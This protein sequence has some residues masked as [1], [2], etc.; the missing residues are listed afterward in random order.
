M[1]KQGDILNTTAALPNLPEGQVFSKA[2]FREAV[3]K[4]NPECSEASINWMLVT[5]RK[6]GILASAGAGKYYVVPKQTKAKMSYQYPH[7]QEYRDLEN[8]VLSAYPLVSFQMWE[9][10]QMNDFVNHQ[11]AKNVIFV[12]VESMMTDT[13]YETLHEQYPYAMI[14]PDIN[15]FFKQRAPGTDIVVQKLITEAPRPVYDRSSPL[16]KIIV[17]LFS[18]KLSGNLIERS[19]Y[20]RIVE[21]V[22]RKYSIDETKLL[23]YARRRHLYNTLLSFIDS[24]TEVKLMT[25]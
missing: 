9:L 1:Y 16:E 4:I 22:F 6:Q 8:A 24:Q 11:I 3:H 18:N 15:V 13:V 23:R 19:E 21:D 14:Q 10:I 5:L 2:C 20:P 7:S 12:E 25:V 17:D